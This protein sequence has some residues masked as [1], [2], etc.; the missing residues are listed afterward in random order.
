MARPLVGSTVP[1]RD[2][3]GVIRRPASLLRLLLRP[4]LGLGDHAGR[5]VVE[6][7]AAAGAADV[8]RLPLVADGDRA[9]PLGDDAD[10]RRIARGEGDALPG[11]S[12]LAEPGE[13]AGGV[14]ALQEE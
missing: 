9:A 7:V 12:D 6:Q 5:V 4:R 14:A 13:P 1:P 2:R 11:V 10:G 8:V 3:R